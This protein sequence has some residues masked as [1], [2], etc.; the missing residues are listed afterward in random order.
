MIAARLHVVDDEKELLRC[1][2]EHPPNCPPTGYAMWIAGE[3][4][5]K[6]GGFR[7][8]NHPGAMWRTLL[9]PVEAVDA[10]RC[11]CG[12]RRAVEKLGTVVLVTRVPGVED[13]WTTFLIEA[14]GAIVGMLVGGWMMGGGDDQGTVCHLDD[15]V[16][17]GGEDLHAR[18]GCADC[19][20]GA[21]GALI[22]RRVPDR[23]QRP[24]RRHQP[25][26]RL[27]HPARK[28]C[29]VEPAKE[30]ARRKACKGALDDP[31]VVG[32]VLEVYCLLAV[33]HV[34]QH[35]GEAA[36]GYLGPF[37]RLRS[38]RQAARGE[39]QGGVAGEAVVVVRCVVLF[40]EEKF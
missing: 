39:G 27:L 34:V 4:C 9:C 31:V 38:R 21:G 1:I 8:G 17:R 15:R 2:D 11:V 40:G 29:Q 3:Q 10:D 36:F 25:G 20:C 28:P 16:T 12:R 33:D 14:E 5:I 6:A 37:L 35:S 13:E 19:C 18:A 7:R 32:R 30:T 24:I 23:R 26:A 22:H